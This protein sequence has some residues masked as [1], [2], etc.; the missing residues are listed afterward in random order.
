M[1]AQLLH[2][3]YSG[4][5][6]LRKAEHSILMVAASYM[7]MTRTIQGTATLFGVLSKTDG[8]FAELLS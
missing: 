8:Q 7:L 4:M 2:S 1:R 3:C 5:F 6:Q